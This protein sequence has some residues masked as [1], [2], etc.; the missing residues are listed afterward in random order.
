MLSGGSINADEAIK[1]VYAE[2]QTENSK[3][4]LINTS[5]HETNHTVTLK[6]TKLSS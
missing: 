1:Q 4:H 6:V 3:L 5:L 2:L